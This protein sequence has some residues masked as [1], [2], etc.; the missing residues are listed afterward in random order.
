MSE[1]SPICILYGSVFTFVCEEKE[2]EHE[3]SVKVHSAHNDSCSSR[4]LLRD[5]HH[6]CLG[7][8][9]GHALTHA[10]L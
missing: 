4:F 1:I 2:G 10:G 3:V 6:G 9:V 5:K 8:C 7:S